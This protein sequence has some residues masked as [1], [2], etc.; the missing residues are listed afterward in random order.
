LATFAAAMVARREIF[1]TAT[2]RNFGGRLG[3]CPNH[4]LPAGW[5]KA[6]D[7][8]ERRSTSED[9]TL[10]VASALSPAASALRAAAS[11][12]LFVAAASFATDAGSTPSINSKA[13]QLANLVGDLGLRPSVHR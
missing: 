2:L 6:M 12:A 10:R 8:F 4:A 5:A 13:A 3:E 1:S 11:I 9:M 7:N